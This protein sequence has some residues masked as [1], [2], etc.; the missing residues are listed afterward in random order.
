MKSEIYGVI[1]ICTN[2]VN[3]KQYVGQT[4]A[5]DPLGYWLR[6]HCYAARCGSKKLFHKAIRKYGEI[7]F[8]FEVIWYANDKISLDLSEDSFIDLFNTMAPNGYNLKT[9]G[10]RGK[11]SNELKANHRVIMKEVRN[12]P[13]ILEQTATN[14]RVFHARPATKTK[15]RAAIK[16]ALNAPGMH[17]ILSAAITEGLA[18]PEVRQKLASATRDSWTDPAIRKRRLDGIAASRDKA[19]TALTGQ[20]WINNGHQ[21]KKLKVNQELPEGWFFGRANFHIN[22]TLQ[23]TARRSASGKAACERPEVIERK[24]AAAT[25]V[26]S[27]PGT[28]ERKSEAC[29]TGNMTPEV[30]A[31]RKARLQH[32]QREAGTGV[33]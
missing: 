22:T 9:G 1:Y 31:E 10:A 21:N 20:R 14:S 24:R 16:A 28:R 26:D 13:E 17:E 15:H 19:S 30:V 11:F 18:P 2:I 12:R 29:Y 3:G 5:A 25:E 7:A 4:T 27:R 32:L 6:A 23:S 33:V 8:T